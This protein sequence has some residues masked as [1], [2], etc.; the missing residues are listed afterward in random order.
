MADDRRRLGAFGE[1]AARNHLKRLGYRIIE[2]NFRCPIGEIDIVA[3]KQ[4]CLVF[5]EV[6]TRRSTGFGIPE[7]SITSS[8]KAKLAALAET[9]IQSH[10]SSPSSWRIDV[11]AIEVTQS[12]A[13]S[14]IEVIENAVS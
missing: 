14:R 6:R 8:K 5:V 13:I 2:S 4:D 1:E 7:E 10:D 3:S 12:G 9:Y 11:V